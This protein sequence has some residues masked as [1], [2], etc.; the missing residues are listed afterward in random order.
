MTP[1]SLR[2][3]H[4]LLVSALPS[5]HDQLLLCTHQT[6]FD[7]ETKEAIQ[8]KGHP[9][10][11]S[12]HPRSEFSQHLQRTRPLH[13]VRFP[14]PQI[15]SSVE[16]S[17][18]N[19]PTRTSATGTTSDALHRPTSLP[20]IHRLSYKRS[21][22]HPNPSTEVVRLVNL[23]LHQN[24]SGHRAPERRDPPLHCFSHTS[25]PGLSIAPASPNGRFC[26]S[27]LCLSL[28]SP[29]FENSPDRTIRNRH[30]RS[31]C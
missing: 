18:C 25:S 11:L 5:L 7:H 28:R 15:Q 14:H 2:L 20:P 27:P 10:Q 9:Y 22:R 23:P 21:L 29:N 13:L 30:T 24:A 1:D 6:T 12:I 16:D 31:P 4:E 19:S 17:S 8:T 3:H 26:R